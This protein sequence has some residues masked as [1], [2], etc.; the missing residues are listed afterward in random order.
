MVSAYKKFAQDYGLQL[1]APVAFNMRNCE[2]EIER[3][4]AWCDEHINTT[5]SLLTQ[6]K[7]KITQ[8]F[9]EEVTLS[10]RQA[11]K[12]ASRECA[13][14]VNNIS[15]PL[16]TQVREYEEQLERR[17][18]AVSRIHKASNS[19]EERLA[20]VQSGFRQTEDKIAEFQKMSQRIFAMFRPQ[21]ADSAPLFEKTA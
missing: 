11:V 20:T 6:D 9:F 13:A 10:V 21:L 4:H 8:R 1:A 12:K 18:E 16:E 7:R 14:W 15:I 5:L 17:V 2:K 3:L 19:L